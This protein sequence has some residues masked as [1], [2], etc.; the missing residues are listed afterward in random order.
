MLVLTNTPQ[1]V[2]G[3]CKEGVPGCILGRPDRRPCPGPEWRPGTG[4]MV[5]AIKKSGRMSDAKSLGWILRPAGS[6]PVQ[7]HSAHVVSH[8]NS[9]CRLLPHGFVTSFLWVTTS[10]CKKLKRKRK[11]DR[12]KCSTD[13]VLQVVKVRIAL[14]RFVPFCIWICQGVMCLLMAKARLDS[15][16]MG[17]FWVL[18]LPPL[19][20]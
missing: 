9:N 10:I 16:S 12:I 5:L 15:T 14:C 7:L 19:S 1:A 20:C 3:M 2:H 6:N 4:I 18:R 13:R 17:R 11:Q 8:R